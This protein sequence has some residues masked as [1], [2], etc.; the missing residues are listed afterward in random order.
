MRK[1][2]AERSGGERRYREG[3]VEPV[4]E[5]DRVDDEAGRRREEEEDKKKK[6]PKTKNRGIRTLRAL[7]RLGRN[8]RSACA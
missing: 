1:R 5:A 7:V 8:S 6:K 3:G 2:D 4:D